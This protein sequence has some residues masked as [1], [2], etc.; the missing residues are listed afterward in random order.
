[1]NCVVATALALLTTSVVAKAQDGMK[2][3][4]EELVKRQE[5]PTGFSTVL[6]SAATAAASPVKSATSAIA[7]SN[8][9]SEV[10]SVYSEATGMPAMWQK[11]IEN[12]S[13]STKIVIGI[14]SALLIIALISMTVCLLRCCGFRRRGD[15]TPALDEKPPS[16]FD[17]RAT[18]LPKTKNLGR[19]KSYRM[20]TE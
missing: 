12:L 3:A 8:V 13:L 17:D 19:R 4:G 20:F 16:A 6:K 2:V 7:D 10:Q 5:V 14:L 1:M 18:S 15:Q 11:E 9:F